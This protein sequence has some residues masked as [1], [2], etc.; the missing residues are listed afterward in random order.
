MSPPTRSA[1][2]WPLAKILF[3]GS[4][5]LALG[6]GTQK[7]A[8]TSIEDAEAAPLPAN[9]PEGTV[10]MVMDEPITRA[11]IDRWVDI[12][13]QIEPGKTKHAIRRFVVTNYNLPVAVWRRPGP[14]RRA[15]LPR[16]NSSAPARKYSPV[17]PSPGKTPP[18]RVCTT[19]GSRKWAWT[20]GVWAR[21]P[22]SANGPRSLKPSAGSPWCASL[23]PPDPWLP[24]S[25]ITLEHLTVYYLPPD[26][27]K[28][29]VGQGLTELPIRAVDSE[30]DRYLP[31][32]YLHNSKLP[33]SQ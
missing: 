12:F 10:Y 25:E 23:A 5:G 3:L 30:W 13:Q 18:S 14:G 4:L 31:T 8:E 28:D 27:S 32:F 24:N 6:C 21:R 19:T 2:S 17:K 20:A 11:E 15:R 22:P 33:Q 7:V 26:Q 9:L 16:K 29:I 1:H